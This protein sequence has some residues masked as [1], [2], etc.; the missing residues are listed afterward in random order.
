MGDMG[1][2]KLLLQ[3]TSYF[4]DFP[5]NKGSDL[6]FPIHETLP[7]TNSRIFG[8]PSSALI[9]SKVRA[10]EMFSK[11]GPPTYVSNLGPFSN[12]FL[13]V[14]T[15]CRRTRLCLSS[16]R[17]VATIKM[18]KTNFKKKIKLLQTVSPAED[19]FFTCENFRKKFIDNFAIFPVIS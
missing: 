11:S 1:E 3:W 12:K 19:C 16:R 10:F 15:A 5:N 2:G 8:S 18:Q 14:W 4:K 13:A 9:N 17:P 7:K 6:I